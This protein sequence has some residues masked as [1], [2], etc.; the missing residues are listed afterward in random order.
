MKP[1]QNPLP[2]IFLFLF[3]VGGASLIM[4][5]S[6]QPPGP[7][8]ASIPVSEFSAERAFR[9]VA[10]FPDEPRPV[11]TDAHLQTRNYTE[12]GHKLRFW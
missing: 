6:Q 5:L 12:H 1:K 4:F 2:A 3:L 11:G 9:H 7:L 10:A 8:P